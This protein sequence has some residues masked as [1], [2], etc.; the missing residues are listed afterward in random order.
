MPTY[1]V[2]VDGHEIEIRA[3]YWSARESV[4]VDGVEVSRK[5]SWQFATSHGFEVRDKS[6]RTVVFEAEVLAGF[7]IGF[8]LRRDGILIAASP[9]NTL[10]ENKFDA[11]SGGPGWSAPS[12]AS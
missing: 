2:P 11:A 7:R 3:S 1:R 4:F 12:R 5:S 8:A 9:R 10:D 6:G